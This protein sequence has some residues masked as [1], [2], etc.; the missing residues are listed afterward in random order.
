MKKCIGGVLVALF[1]PSFNDVVVV[2]SSSS[3]AVGHNTTP[4]DIIQDQDI[5]QDRDIIKDPDVIILKDP[6][7]D[8]EDDH[9][10]P[11]VGIRNVQPICPSN[12]DGN[13]GGGGD[14]NGDTQQHH[15]GC[16]VREMLVS[17]MESDD[18][19]QGKLRACV[20][21]TRHIKRTTAVGITMIGYYRIS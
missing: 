17:A 10:P 21:V 9:P 11:T 3:L 5:I 6:E 4:S 8:P 16:A 18:R 12:N 7:E 19:L 13:T 14:D 1:F 20:C 15:R 2:A